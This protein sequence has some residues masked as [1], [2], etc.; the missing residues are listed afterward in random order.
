MSFFFLEQFV[1]LFE[2]EEVVFLH[3]VE[4]V[5]DDVLH[6]FYF[7][8]GSFSDGLYFEV[9][10]KELALDWWMVTSAVI[11]RTTV[12]VSGTLVSIVCN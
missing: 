11:L 4:L 6:E 10:V 2:D 5:V 1:L 8:V 12:F 3:G 9:L 7:G